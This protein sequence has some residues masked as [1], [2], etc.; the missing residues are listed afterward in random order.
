MA[1][2]RVKAL[3]IAI[4]IAIERGIELDLLKETVEKAIKEEAIIAE[5]KDLDRP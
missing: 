5:R 3:A 4:A 2:A 1:K